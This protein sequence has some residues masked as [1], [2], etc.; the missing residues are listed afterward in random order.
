MTKGY[1]FT[2]NDAL[3]QLSRSTAPR[4]LIIEPV[5]IVLRHRNRAHRIDPRH[6][7]PQRNDEAGDEQDAHGDDKE[8]AHSSSSRGD[9]GKEMPASSSSSMSAR[10][11]VSRGASDHRRTA[12]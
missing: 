6:W 5:P 2:S 4:S 8:A 11:Q 9:N 7:R 12:A 10:D 1:I 3:Q